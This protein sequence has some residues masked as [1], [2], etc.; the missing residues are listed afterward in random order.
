VPV[1]GFNSGRYDLN[2]IREN[3]AEI[4]CVQQ[5]N[6]KVEIAKKDNKIMFLTTIISFS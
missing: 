5:E 6:N 3:F 2:L 1:L 4:I